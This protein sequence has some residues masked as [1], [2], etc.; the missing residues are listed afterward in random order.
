MN[1]TVGA[2]DANGNSITF[3]ISIK[4]LKALMITKCYKSPY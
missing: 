3:Q 1:P 4:F 2:L